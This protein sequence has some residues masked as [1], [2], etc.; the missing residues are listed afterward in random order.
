ML[1]LVTKNY[2]ITS[3][4]ISYV[5]LEILHMVRIQ[6]TLYST[7]ELFIE[8]IPLSLY[9]IQE[10][11]IIIIILFIFNSSFVGFKFCQN[12]GSLYTFLTSLSTLYS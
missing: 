7:Y 12:F 9:L 3:F 1:I 4:L 2:Y 6:L 11:I 8:F 5:S 10:F